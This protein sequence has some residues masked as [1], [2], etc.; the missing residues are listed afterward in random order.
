M[1]L[2]T[3]YSLA[4]AGM[5]CLGALTTSAYAQDDTSDNTTTIVRHYHMTSGGNLIR[6]IVD[7]Q[8]VDFQGPGPIMVGG[9]HVMVPIRGVFEQMGGDVQ[10]DPSSQTITGARRGHMFQIRVGSQDGLVNGNQITLA[11]AP[12]LIGGTTYVPLRFAGES[13]GAS[14]HWHADTNTVSIRTHGDEG[15]TTTIITHSPQ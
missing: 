2:K 11:A 7:N 15:T 9:D 5:L 13:L 8:P 10:W 12:L 3:T 1:K 6:V 14:V 4:L